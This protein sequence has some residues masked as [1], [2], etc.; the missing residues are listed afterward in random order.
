MVSKWIGKRGADCG[1]IA[2]AFDT[3]KDESLKATTRKGIMYKSYPLQDDW[4]QLT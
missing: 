4:Y 3:Y 1:T 2:V